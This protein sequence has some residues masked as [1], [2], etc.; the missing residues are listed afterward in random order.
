MRDQELEKYLEKVKDILT[1]SDLCHMKTLQGPSQLLDYLYIGNKQEAHKIPLLKALG[2]THVLNCCGRK[3]YSNA[4]FDQNPYS[5]HSIC[6]EEIEALDNDGYPILGLHFTKCRKFID[7]AKKDGGRVFVHCEM[8]INRSGAICAAYM[9]LDQEMT[10][11]QTLRL[12]KM[13][14]ASLICND[15]FQRQLIEFA[16]DHDL[17]YR[18]C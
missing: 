16:R 18:S 11:T 8:G 13:E 4:D 2:I 1:S 9:M 6:Y 5:K 3:D 17:L 7:R 15:G 10:L 14:R 12:I